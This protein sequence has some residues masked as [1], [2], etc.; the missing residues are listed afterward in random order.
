L[1]AKEFWECIHEHPDLEWL[2][3]KDGHVYVNRVGCLKWQLTPSAIRENTWECLEDIL[4]G[5]TDP[6][7]MKHVSRVIGYYSN[8][9]N[10][11]RSKLAELDG[12][13]AGNYAFTVDALKGLDIGDND[14]EKEEEKEI[15]Q[16]GETC[17]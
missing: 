10:W 6:V 13:R 12:R 1:T 2:G 16:K 7:R 9:A 4:M 14:G 5:R 17:Q 3:V 11:N 15:N 8:I